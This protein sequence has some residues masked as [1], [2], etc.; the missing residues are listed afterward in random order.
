MIATID[1]KP[2]IFDFEISQSFGST[3][4]SFTLQIVSIELRS[5]AS[6]VVK[7]GWRCTV[8]YTKIQDNGISSVC[9]YQVANLASLR[10]SMG[11]PSRTLGVGVWHSLFMTIGTIV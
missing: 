3:G 9:T 7:R 5:E 1:E 2:S 6:H 4:Y 11:T 8:L 10:D